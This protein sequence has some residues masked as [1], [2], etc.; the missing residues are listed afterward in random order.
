M[1]RNVLVV[2]FLALALAGCGSTRV[3]APVSD[4][5]GERRP[6]VATKPGQRADTYVV[7]RGDTLYSIA[8]EQ[9]V[10]H[11]ELARVN[12]IA[13]PSALA[14]GRALTIPRPVAAAPPPAPAPQTGFVTAPIAVGPAVEAKPLGNSPSLKSEPKGYKVPYSESAL[15]DMKRGTTV[16]LAKPAAP[17]PGPQAAEVAPKEPAAEP[18]P[19]GP[20]AWAWPVTG[21]VVTRFSD[22]NKG[23]DI[24]GQ[25]GQPVHASAPGKVVYKGDGLRGY[26]LLVI[27]KHNEE[28]LSAYAHNRSVL[29]KEGDAV[30][31][32]QK[33][34]EMGDSD[35][36]RVKLHFEIRRFG[37]PVDPLRYL[38]GDKPS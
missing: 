34:A 6:E 22:A 36:D 7:K 28:Y 17:A 13:D 12:G 15:A 29:V 16:A 23:I 27:I 5:S 19:D 37:K 35:A 25:A 14:V 20:I 4:R 8:L 38:P 32:G 26:G 21:K 2:A 9:G 30:S 3:G 33:I 31:R 18:A 24:A 11:R 10:D 1:Q